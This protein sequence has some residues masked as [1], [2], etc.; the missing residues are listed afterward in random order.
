MYLELIL[1]WKVTCNQFLAKFNIDS[2][3]Q[4]NRNL[5][6]DRFLFWLR[7]EFLIIYITKNNL[8]IIERFVY[9]NN[10]FLRRPFL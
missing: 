2:R 5:Y 7:V 8:Y 6:L 9:K 4:S 1:H 10:L 3:N